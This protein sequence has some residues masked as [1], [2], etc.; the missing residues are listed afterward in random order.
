MTPHRRATLSTTR[1]TQMGGTVYASKAAYSG[2]DHAETVHAGAAG[3]VRAW[4]KRLIRSSWLWALL[5][6]LPALI[7]L[8]RPGFFKSDDGL[9]HVYRIAALA[10]A[11]QHGVLYPRLFPQFGFG[12]GQAVL[13]YYAPLGYVPGALL[14][15]LGMSPASAT[16]WSIAIG[17]ILAG[18]AA[19]G[20]GKYLWGTA[21]GL[22]AS[23]V[24][25]YFP[26]HLA[27]AY[28]RGALP[29]QLAFIFLPLI[30]W[31]TVAAFREEQPVPSYLWSA[32]AWAGLVY[33]H[34][35]TVLLMVLAWGAL[36]LFMALTT[37][38]WRRFWGSVGGAA[39]GAGLSAWLWL[40]FL[41]ESKL[42]GIGLGPSDGALQHLAPLSQLVQTLPVYQYRVAQGTGLAEHPLGWPAILLCL[43]V[44][45]WLLWR[46]ARR[47]PLAGIGLGVFGLL[48][49]ASAAYM[50]AASSLPVWRTFLPF[51]GQFQYPWRFMALV[52]LGLAM[53]AGMA[54][55]G[56]RLSQPTGEWRKHTGP[57]VL[58]LIALLTGL[59]FVVG[60][61]ARVP[62]VPLAI[63]G[64]EAWGTVRMWTED[65]AAGQVGATWTGE[66]LPQTVKE[67]RWA[68]GRPPEG[69]QDGPSLTPAPEVTLSRIGYDRL[70]LGLDSNPPTQLRLH[71]FYLPAWQAWIDGEAEATYPSGELGLVTLDL[72]QQASKV[73]FRFGPTRAAVASSLIVIIAALAWALLAWNH[74]WHARRSDRIGLTVA[75]PLVVLLPLLVLANSIGVGVKT[76]TP[77]AV[78]ST[79]S[80]V[81]QLVA[82]DTEAAKGERALDV[83]L[84]WLALRETAQNYKVFVHLLGPDGQVVTQEDGDPVG[85]YTPT[86]RWKQGELIA[87]THRLSLPDA[88]PAGQYELRAGMYEVR[89]GETPGFVNLPT[90]PA[91][92]DGRIRLGAV[93]IR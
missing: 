19:F 91:T 41:A 14:A 7:P 52:A 50:T 61:L 33:T 18:L 25:T 60:G 20:M 1:A 34:N 56:L 77:T 81:A 88:L 2:T 36:I 46:Y 22:L 27:D 74:R 9:F 82:Y 59:S 10:D 4:G 90:T 48:L 3:Q 8:L 84:Y 16:E 32:L 54:L 75:A 76:W 26:Y 35:L 24:Y 49:A 37:R 21:G 85:G 63:T 70:S 28:V 73:S 47:Q 12:Y 66:F 6:T 29:E 43:L 93:E 15:L 40:P 92:E 13:N 31:S 80:N 44:I 57:F 39:L 11:W 5:L 67:Q 72:P 78:N 79:A 38:K 42:V 65:A 64:A 53:A 51:L 62:T 71:Q 58:V 89:P 30:V 69:A 68:L 55:R 45:G 83:T 86:T 23:V 17:F 87:D